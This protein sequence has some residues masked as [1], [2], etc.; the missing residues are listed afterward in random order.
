M[1]SI[2]KEMDETLRTRGVQTDP[3]TNKEYCSGYSYGQ[4]YDWDQ[5]FESIVQFYLGWDTKFPKNTVSIFLDYQDEAGFIPR[6]V[7]HSNGCEEQNHEHVKPFLAQI[8]LLI[9][10]K[11]SSLE[12]LTDEYYQKMKKYLMGGNIFYE[13]S[14]IILF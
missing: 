5:Y 1:T 2:L 7:G 11:D 12:F 4:L 3:K 13:K 9:Y 6:G 10:N 14:G 8:A